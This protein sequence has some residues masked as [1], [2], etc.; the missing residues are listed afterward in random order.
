[1]FTT[2]IDQV[3]ERHLQPVE[4]PEE[5]WRRVQ[6]ARTRPSR[7]FSGRLAWALAAL[8]PLLAVVWTLRVTQ[9]R[10]GEIRCGD[11]A[12]MRRWIA[13]KT[14]LDVPLR[15]SPAIR[16]ESARVLASVAVP[17]VE[18]SFRTGEHA[19]TLRVSRTVPGHGGA[20]GHHFVNRDSWMVGN[21]VY[22]IDC[23]E[24]P[25]AGCTLCHAL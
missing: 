6:S 9:E 16:L 8:V 17:T 23:P 4:A 2:G 1:M 13:A 19:A 18:L 15:P 3:L 25:R 21:Q 14:D 12:E 11:A 24:D 10:L 7:A 20:S 5:L 22:V